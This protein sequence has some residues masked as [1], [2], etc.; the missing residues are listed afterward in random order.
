VRVIDSS[1]LVKYFSHEAG[2]EKAREIILEG[3]LTLDL[4]IKEVVSA[5]WKKVLRGCFVVDVYR[6]GL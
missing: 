3:M 4:A 5:L 1:T 2:W 6:L